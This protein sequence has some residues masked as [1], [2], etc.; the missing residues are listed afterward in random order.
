M[1]ALR[2]GIMKNA[3]LGDGEVHRT[4]ALEIVGRYYLV[5]VNLSQTSKLMDILL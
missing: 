1:L 2:L 3:S 5:F 4:N